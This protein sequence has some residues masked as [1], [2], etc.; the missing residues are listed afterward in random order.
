MGD[1]PEAQFVHVSKMKGSPE[2]WLTGIPPLALHSLF[3]GSSEQSFPSCSWSGLPISHFILPC[4][5]V[6]SLQ[7]I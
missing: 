1:Y 7:K 2:D 5:K 4:V 3:Q 6:L